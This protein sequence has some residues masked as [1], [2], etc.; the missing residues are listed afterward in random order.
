MMVGDQYRYLGEVFLWNLYKK[1]MRNGFWTRLAFGGFKFEVSRFS[2][3]DLEL[4]QAYRDVRML[5]LIWR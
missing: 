3:K 1:I 5:L 4:Q 2:W